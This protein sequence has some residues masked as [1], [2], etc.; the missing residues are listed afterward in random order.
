MKY[1]DTDESVG[2]ITENF[3]SVMAEEIENSHSY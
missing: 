1:I 3:K 2:R